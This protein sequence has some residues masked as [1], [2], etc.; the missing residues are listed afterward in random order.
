MNYKTTYYKIIENAKKETELG[1]RQVGY[2]EKHHILPKSLGGSNE[3]NNLVKLTAR[4]H[5]IC[6]WLLVK[7]YDKG[8]NERYKMLCALWRMN[9]SG[10]PAQKEHYINS[11]AYE[12]LRIEFASKIREVT[13]IAQCGEKNSQYGTKWYTNRNTGESKKFKEKPDETWIN[14]RNVFNKHELWSIETK[15]PLIWRNNQFSNSMVEYKKLLNIKKDKTKEKIV[16]LWQNYY[17]CDFSLPIFAEMNNLS[18]DAL[19]MQFKTYIPEFKKI[20]KKIKNK[21][22]HKC[23]HN[24]ESIKEKT[25]LRAQEWWNM[26]H[27]G[28]FNNLAEFAK[29][30]DTSKMTIYNTFAK[31]IPIMKKLKGK[32]KFKSNPELINIFE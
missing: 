5:F 24:T 23:S 30:I 21:C 19:Y 22:S 1:N 27:S 4:E 9:N 11:R 16:K 15:Q 3:E 20:N 12:K 8:S 14:G 29:S 25:K 26:L 18:Y 7:M 31:Y 17:N 28:N 6:H 2:F 13:S 10:A 32:S